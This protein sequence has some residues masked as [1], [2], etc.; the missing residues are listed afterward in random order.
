MFKSDIDKTTQ[1]FETS[2]FIKNKPRYFLM[3]QLDID[4]ISRSEWVICLLIL[5]ILMIITRLA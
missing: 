2:F 3:D 4:I 1:T 5:Q